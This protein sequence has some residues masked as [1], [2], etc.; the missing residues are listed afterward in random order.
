MGGCQ[1][2]GP[3]LGT[4]GIR[5][6]TILG[7]QKGTIILTPTQIPLRAS[8][9][10]PSKQC[11]AFRVFWEPELP[12]ATRHRRPEEAAQGQGRPA[13]R[14]RAFSEFYKAS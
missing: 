4:L 7:T 9:L 11:W 14:A 12:G 2:Y 3:F 8:K 10:Q 5:C 1:D 6:R 13:L